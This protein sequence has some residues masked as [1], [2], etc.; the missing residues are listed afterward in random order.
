M[1][2]YNFML[3][4]LRD[5][6][7]DRFDVPKTLLPLSPT[8]LCWNLRLLLNY[9]LGSFTLHDSAFYAWECTK[10]KSIRQQSMPQNNVVDMAET[11]TLKP[12]NLLTLHVQ[13]YDFKNAITS[14]LSFPRAAWFLVSYYLQ[15][16]NLSR[17]DNVTRN[18]FSMQLVKMMVKEH[19]YHCWLYIP[20]GTASAQ[21]EL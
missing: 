2:A 16:C 17:G 6:I 3:Y 20:G 8:F 19:Y 10:K 1:I 11:L 13:S 4:N 18:V 14:I 7:D 5:M 12:S 9:N 21:F 15:V